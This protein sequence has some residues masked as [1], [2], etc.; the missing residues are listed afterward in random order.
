MYVCVRVRVEVRLAHVCG[1]AEEGRVHVLHELLQAVQHAAA[2]LAHQQLLGE[3]GVGVG[4]YDAYVGTRLACLR[5]VY[6]AG[7]YMG[8]WVMLQG[9]ALGDAEDRVGT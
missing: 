7:C 8:G 3:E 9:K 6:R 4:T 1:R 5:H 2:Q